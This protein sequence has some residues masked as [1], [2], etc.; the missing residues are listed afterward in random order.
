V[1]KLKRE[2]RSRR[3]ASRRGT[4]GWDQQRL[5]PRRSGGNAGFAEL[6][7]A[8]LIDA[9]RGQQRQRIRAE[10]SRLVGSGAS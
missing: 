9:L 2:L 8:R 5:P 6:N 7:L 4:I 1:S 10:Q 3:I